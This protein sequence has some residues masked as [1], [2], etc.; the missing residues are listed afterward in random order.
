MS[1]T[2][3]NPG[4]RICAEGASRARL[5]RPFA[6]RGAETLGLYR[7]G[8]CG[9]EYLDPQPS[10]AWLQSNYAGYFAKRRASLDHPKLEFFRSLLRRSGLDLSGRR[11]LEI[12]AAEGDGVL[13]VHSLWPDCRITALDGHPE[14]VPYSRA[15]PCQF[16]SESVETWLGHP[17]DGRYDACLMLDV[18]EHL[19][20]PVAVLQALA[21]T[22]LLP[23]ALLLATFPNADAASRRLLG[24]FWPHY[25]AEHLYYLSRDGV[26]ALGRRCGL[27]TRRL[28]PLPKRLPLGYVL[29]VA[30][31][32]GPAAVR[33]VGQVARMLMPRALDRVVLRVVMG[34]WLW[35]AQTGE[36]PTG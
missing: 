33:G 8:V 11:V 30:S 25:T 2:A 21:T 7:C 26:G 28:T 31:H 36:D 22:R 16:L 23:G 32:F 6:R 5:L 19:R 14:S 17:P 34:E 20:D 1:A 10:A 29:D 9:C 3:A 35:V 15:L 13:A 18:I 4:C 12:G 24:R 27:R